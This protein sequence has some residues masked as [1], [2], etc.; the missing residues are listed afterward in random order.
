MNCRTCGISNILEVGNRYWVTGQNQWHFYKI[1]HYDLG[2]N[3]KDLWE[4]RWEWKNRF[5]KTFFLMCSG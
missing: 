3:W 2:L 1:E 4:E 5:S